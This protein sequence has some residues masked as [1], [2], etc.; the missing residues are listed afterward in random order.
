MINRIM[1]ILGDKALKTDLARLDLSQRPEEITEIFDVSYAND[2]DPGHTFDV[3]LK[4]DGK[5]KPVLIDIHGGGFISEDKAMNRL[6]A[7]YMAMQGFTVFEINVRLAYPDVTVFDQIK[8]ISAAV[9]FILENIDQYESDKDQLY[10]AGHSSGGVLA[11]AETMFSIDPE[12]RQAYGVP[13]RSYS[14]KGLITDCGLMHFYKSSIAYWGMRKMVFPKG[15]MQDIRYKFLINGENSKVAD[16]PKVCLIT[17]RK[18]VLRK[19]TYH[20][21]SVLTGYDVPH[22]LF[23]EGADGHTGI[24]FVPYKEHNQATLKKIRDYLLE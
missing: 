18:D 13:D 12:M 7:N 3:Y 2:K 20:F 11:L 9:S 16:I 24:I 17:N 23:S 8:D 6:W 22:K 4:K 21:D 5:L 1:K 19:M 14:Y 15:Y 10:I